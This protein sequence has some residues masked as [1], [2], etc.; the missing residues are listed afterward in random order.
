MRYEM[1]FIIRPLEHRE[2]EITINKVVGLVNE[3]GTVIKLDNWG[4]KRLAYEIKGE[5]E[6]HY[7]LINF[8]SEFPKVTHL[9]RKMYQIDEVI[10]HMIVWKG[11]EIMGKDKYQESDGDNRDDD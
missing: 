6:G 1:M 2:L 10:R 9:D 11:G 7:M 5:I 3:A 8:D 4:K